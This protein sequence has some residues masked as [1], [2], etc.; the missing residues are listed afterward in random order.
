M[1]TRD[2]NRTCSVSLRGFFLIF[3][4][5][6]AELGWSLAA[7]S[8]TVPVITTTIPAAGSAVHSLTTVELFFSEDV[9]GVDAA[10]LFINGT[11]AS[12]LSSF[13][14]NQYVFTFAEPPPGAVTVSWA[15]DHGIYSLAPQQTLFAP[16]VWSY[17]IDLS[18]FEGAPVITEFMTDNDETLRDEDG[19]SSDWI[20]IY[21]PA[22]EPLEL[23]GW[24]LSNDPLNLA[25]WRFP[26]VTM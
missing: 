16:P 26:A 21:N 24:T 2:S 7:E 9:T 20:E 6:V 5:T 22:N 4:L 10:D 19:D 1:L 11:P 14:A 13:G 25:R 17:T 23:A 12:D 8:T 18:L 15:A 3:C